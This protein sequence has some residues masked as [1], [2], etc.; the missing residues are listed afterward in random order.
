M[1][2]ISAG[3]LTQ[4]RTEARVAPLRLSLYDEAGDLAAAGGDVGEARRTEAREAAGHFAAEDV[5]GEV[6]QH[7]PHLDAVFRL[8]GK[9]FAADRDAFLHYPGARAI[10]QRAL[11][12]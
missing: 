2:L 5:G 4:R 12:G 11:Q 3:A 1:R 8:H 6:D 7:V 10:G 9:N